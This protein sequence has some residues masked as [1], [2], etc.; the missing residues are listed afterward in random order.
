MYE[1]TVRD[2][3]MIAHSFNGAIF[4]PAQQLHGATY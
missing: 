1:L 4:G 3:L 2:H